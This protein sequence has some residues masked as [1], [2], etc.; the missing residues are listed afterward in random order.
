MP[1]HTYECGHLQVEMNLSPAPNATHS[2]PLQGS[3]RPS[4]LHVKWQ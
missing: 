1:R 2:K 4:L 3:Q